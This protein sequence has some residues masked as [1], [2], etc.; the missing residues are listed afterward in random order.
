MWSKHRMPNGFRFMNEI[1]IISGHAKRMGSIQWRMK[2]SHNA[3]LNSNKLFFCWKE[4]KRTYLLKLQWQLNQLI[5]LPE[6]QPYIYSNLF[7]CRRNVCALCKRALRWAP[8]ERIFAQRCKIIIVYIVIIIIRYPILTAC[9]HR[10]YVGC[11]CTH[12]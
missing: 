9:S 4:A 5:I 3:Q 12:Q 7:A 11:S 6:V 8:D 1:W 2:H 10:A